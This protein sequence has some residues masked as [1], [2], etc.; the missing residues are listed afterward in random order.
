MQGKSPT[1]VQNNI[2]NSK[3]NNAKNVTQNAIP[4]TDVSGMRL[5]NGQYVA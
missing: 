3:N 4:A 2:N 5:V 1:V